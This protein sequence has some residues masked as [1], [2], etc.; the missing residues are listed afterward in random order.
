MA[1]WLG[2]RP[3]SWKITLLCVR[4]LALPMGIMT[5]FLIS[6]ANGALYESQRRAG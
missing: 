4:T 2:N 3:L 1:A 5:A 6:G